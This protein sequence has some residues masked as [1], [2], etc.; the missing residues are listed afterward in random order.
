MFI[1]PATPNDH[2]QVLMLA[3]KAGFGMTSLPPD[4]EVLAEKIAH[5]VASFAGTVEAGHESFFFVLEDAEHGSLAGT[6]GI[7]AHVGL[8]QPFYSY[9][10][11]TLTQTSRA[12][13]IYSKH[14]IL[15][16]CNDLTGVSEIGSLFLLP[17]YRRDGM[18]KLLSLSRFMFMAAFTERFDRRVIAEMRGV[19]DS[20]GNAPFYNSI[21]RHFFQMPFAKADYVNATQGNQF[22]ND[23]MPKY[24]I[25][26]SLLPKAAQRV[27]GQPNPASEPAKALLEAQ[28]FRFEEYIDVFDGGPTL[29]AARDDISI[30]KQSIMARVV[31]IDDTIPPPRYLIAND[32]F[33]DY[34]C[35]SARLSVLEAGEVAISPRAAQ[36]LQVEVGDTVRYHPL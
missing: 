36:Q 22:I 32:R 16:V 25:Y 20:D 2:A 17:H 33:A 12:L 28:G 34:R 8:T 30:V 14:T 24:P 15:Q 29:I 4:A 1:R 5:S 26:V 23:L 13:G 27:I 21:A 35:L 18:G 11:T 7:V 19:H 31:R 3:Q 6:C 10:L 9:K